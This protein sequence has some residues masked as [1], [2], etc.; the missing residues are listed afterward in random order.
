VLVGGLVDIQSKP[1]FL[2]KQL[3]AIN[4]R[5]RYQQNFQ[6]HIHDQCSW[7]PMALA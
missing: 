4:V 3:G 1:Q 2:V 5:N 6:L 7:L